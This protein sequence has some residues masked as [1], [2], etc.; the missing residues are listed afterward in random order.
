[1]KTNPSC[2]VKCL[3][4]SFFVLSKV[5]A[6]LGCFGVWASES[7]AKMNPLPEFCVTLVTF[8]ILDAK[9]NFQM[10]FVVVFI[11]ISIRTVL[12][13][14]KVVVMDPQMFFQFSFCRKA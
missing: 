13:F 14:I 1:M 5:Q 6:D 12:T 10:S 7:D 11:F 2:F 4:N 3:S 8:E 9:M